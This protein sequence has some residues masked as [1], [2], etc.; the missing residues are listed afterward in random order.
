M[1]FNL[2]DMV[3]N[4]KKPTE[5]ENISDTVYRDVFEL[6]PSKE[7]FYS[8]DPEKLQGLKNSILLFG[9]M[10]DVR[11]RTWMV[12]TGSYQGTVGQ[13]A[14]GCLWKRDM[15]SFGRL[16]VNIQK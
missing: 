5:T 8:T 3:N 7:N 15:K 12:K 4:R 11:L 1:A 2:A 10:Q 9:V 6:E 14:A 13:C 16:T